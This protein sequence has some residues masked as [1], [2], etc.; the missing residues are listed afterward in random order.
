MKSVPREKIIS[1]KKEISYII[2][3]GKKFKG[4]FLS[5]I[6]LTSE[7]KQLRYAVLVGKKNGNAVS[8]NRYKRIIREVVRHNRQLFSDNFYTF[9]VRPSVQAEISF[10]N[11]D[12]EFKQWES[13]LSG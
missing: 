12:R 9:L 11:A 6:Y 3:N 2:K 10:D 8:R 1:G 4:K 13:G 5:I 7:T